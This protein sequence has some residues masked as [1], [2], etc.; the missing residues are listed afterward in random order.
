MI[1]TFEEVQHRQIEGCGRIALD[2]MR[3]H[4]TWERFSC[5]GA[6]MPIATRYW[7]GVQIYS[8]NQS[9]VLSN[10]IAIRLSLTLCSYRSSHKIMAP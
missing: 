2:S 5:V 4:Q 6:T 7:L 8:I 3:L 10:S 1:S 9:A